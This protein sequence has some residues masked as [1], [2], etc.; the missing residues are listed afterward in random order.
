MIFPFL[1]AGSI[2][3]GFSGMD[4][5]MPEIK[6]STEVVID[7]DEAFVNNLY[8]S[9]DLDQV[10]LKKEVLNYAYEGYHRLLEKGLIKH[11]GILTVVDFSQSSKNKRLYLID[12]DNYMLLMN[13]YVAHGKNSGEEFATHFS[14]KPES[15]QSS[16]GF[17]VTRS[18]YNGKHGLSL[19]MEGLEKGFNDNAME[20]AIVLHGS[21]YSDANFV[22]SRGYLGRSWGCPAVPE[23]KKTE[24]INLIKEGT[25]LFIY[26]PT[27]SYLHGSTLLNG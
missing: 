10:G 23:N 21:A 22:R 8:D 18:T 14:N 15:L 13:T 26:H 9:L 2:G 3:T 16:L 25:C 24:I 19:R 1:K 17:Y 4:N 11:P 6:D 20:R 27:E 7:N 12:M 5:I